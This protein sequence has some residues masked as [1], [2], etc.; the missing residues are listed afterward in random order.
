MTGRVFRFTIAASA[1]LGVA[2]TS[3]RSDE[4]KPTEP[5]A[6][7][8]QI[9]DFMSDTQR[10]HFKLGLSGG[11][12][13]WPLAAYELGKLKESLDLAGKFSPNADPKLPDL[14]KASADPGFT[15][16]ES[17]IADENQPAFVA[18][19]NRLTRAC[20]A[21]H[22]ASGVAEIKI[23]TPLTSPYSNQKFAP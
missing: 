7:R 6:F 23:Q 5:P 2:L 10:R 21:C 15:D 1:G 11:L 22:V 4:P 3:A 8:P 13:N 14:S 19:F 16:L 20:N 17:A 18:S 9:S 12:S